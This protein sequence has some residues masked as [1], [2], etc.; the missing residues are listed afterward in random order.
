MMVVV[1]KRS[2]AAICQ[3]PSKPCVAQVSARRVVT[4]AAMAAATVARSMLALASHDQALAVNLTR[5]EPAST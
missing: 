1:V 3:L 5:C 4:V 2:H